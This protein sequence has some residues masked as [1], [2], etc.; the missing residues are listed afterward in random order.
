MVTKSVVIS[1]M[2]DYFFLNSKKEINL[3][4]APSWWLC[5]R[6]ESWTGGWQIGGPL[7]TNPGT[8]RLV[9]PLETRTMWLVP[10]LVPSVTI[11]NLFIPE[12]AKLFWAGSVPGKTPKGVSWN[13]PLK[14]EGQGVVYIR[15]CL[16]PCG[17]FVGSLPTFLQS[18]WSRKWN[19]GCDWGQR[20]L[21]TSGCVFH[22]LPVM[23]RIWNWLFVS[24]GLVGL[25]VEGWEEERLN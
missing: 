20:V 13:W 12:G 23:A 18:S 3:G 5:C 7:P 21:G 1:F 8:F 14:V 22:F 4:K 15:A 24:V 19:V 25:G 6:T 10:D 11:D 2:F 17:T 16:P 9:Q